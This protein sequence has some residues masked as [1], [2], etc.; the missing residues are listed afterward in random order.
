MSTI[1]DWFR[2]QFE[3]FGFF[4]KEYGFSL[5]FFFN[6]SDKK[7]LHTWVLNIKR[8]LTSLFDSKMVDLCP[9]IAFEICK[10][11]KNN[12][13]SYFKMIRSCEILGWEVK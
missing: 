11:H 1:L 7:T 3:F 8:P 6:N 5:V 9:F 12:L 10:D 4:K 2:R 13:D